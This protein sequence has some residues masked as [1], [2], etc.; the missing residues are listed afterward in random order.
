MYRA[1]STPIS[2]LPPL[3][4]YAAGMTM[5]AFFI[6]DLFAMRLRDPLINSHPRWDLV[7]KAIRKIRKFSNPEAERIDIAESRALFIER[8]YSEELW[9]LF[10]R[11]I[12]ADPTKRPSID[13]VVETLSPK[14]PMA[15]PPEP[16]KQAAAAGVGGPAVPTVAPR[17]G[18]GIFGCFG[19]GGRRTKR[20]KK[21]ATL[22][23]D[24]SNTWLIGNNY[25]RGDSI[26]GR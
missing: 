20:H 16:P 9:T 2:L 21:I 15:A 4:I 6:N 3:D 8:G 23:P 5:F 1:A 19:R 14:A 7:E 18:C 22:R 24:D 26:N 25:R 12:D 11:M 13:E 17:V 10:L